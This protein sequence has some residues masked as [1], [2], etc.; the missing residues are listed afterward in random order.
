MDGDAS[1]GWGDLI[2]GFRQEAELRMDSKQA[3]AAAAIATRFLWHAGLP[4]CGG[5]RPGE[6]AE[7]LDA[8][9]VNRYL[10]G[11]SRGGA[12]LK[13]LHNH[14][15]AIAAFL[16]H[17]VNLRILPSNP[18]AAV[19]LRKLEKRPARWLTDEEVSAAMSVARQR[20][21]WPE[22]ALAVASGLRLSELRR[23][24]WMDVDSQRSTLL[25]RKAK[26]KRWRTVPLNRLAVAALDEQWKISGGLVHVFPARRT[27]RGGWAWKDAPR[28][29][30]WWRKAMAPIQD[31]V[32]KFRQAAGTGRGWHLLRHTF[33]SRLA[34]QGVDLYQ[35]AEW[36][37]H[38][39]TRT[40]Q[41]YAHLAAGYNPLIER[42]CSRGDF[43]NDKNDTTT[44]GNARC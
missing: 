2:D 33:A 34:Q 32:P 39:D 20:G 4:G 36:L 5:L 12:S 28:A 43:C 25:V 27:W 31:A 21:T 13:T 3:K 35:I 17:L 19:R 26:G 42:A 8:A 23:L 37:G 16:E 29:A 38:T 9:A 44:E 30:N 7:R 15:W 41:M 18:A 6:P 24:I 11:V 14:R 1:Q 10:A 22:V 40:T